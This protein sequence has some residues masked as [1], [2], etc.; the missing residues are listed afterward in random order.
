MAYTKKEWTDRNVQYP[1]RRK[2][3]AVS[4]QTDVYD[5]VR[6]EGTITAAGD[7]FS[8]ENMNDLEDRIDTG[9]TQAKTYSDSQLKTAK[10]YAD[11]AV[12]KAIGDAMGGDY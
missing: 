7:A 11:D 8:A 1:G 9:F 5:V 2:L 4:G 3:S 10:E 6:N 12:Q